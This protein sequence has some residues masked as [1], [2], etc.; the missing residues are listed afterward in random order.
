V[1]VLALDSS[2]LAYLITCASPNL[3]RGRLHV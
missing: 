2:F 1:V 3:R